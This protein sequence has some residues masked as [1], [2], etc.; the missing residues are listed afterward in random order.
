ME[1]LIQELG[2]RFEPGP[3]LRQ[4]V[5]ENRL[6]RKTGRGFFEYQKTAKT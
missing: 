5:A 1:S 4:M 2:E 6:G 3:I